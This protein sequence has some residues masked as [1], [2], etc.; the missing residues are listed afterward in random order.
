MRMN[1]TRFLPALAVFAIGEGEARH[2]DTIEKALQA[3][4]HRAPPSGEHEDEVLGPGDKVYGIG[5]AGL[6]RLVARRRHQDIRL[7]IEI[8]ERVTAHLG[9]GV[10][11]ARCIGIG[12]GLAE[13]AAT[14]MTE[15]DE[16]LR[17][18][19]SMLRTDW[20]LGSGWLEH[21]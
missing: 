19:R 8:R 10:P 20:P 21:R 11:R 7:K 5:D 17:R 9:A 12:Q 2:E 16:N 1:F 6:Q 15:H 4:G 14:G 18:P 13:A 3:G